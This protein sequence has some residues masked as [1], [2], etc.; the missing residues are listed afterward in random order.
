M[1]ARLAALCL[2][3]TALG[4]CAIVQDK[5]LGQSFDEASASNQIKSRL[6]AAGASRF[7]EVDVEV[8]GGLA[9]L[10]GRVV[11]PEDRVAA[12]RLAWTVAAIDEIANEI[13]VAAQ[14]SFSGG[15][16]DEWITARV[17]SRLVSDARVKSVN[18]NVETHAGVVYLLGLARSESELAAA[19]EQASLVSGVEKVVSYVKMRDRHRT[20]PVNVQIAQPTAPAPTP[21]PSYS[22]EYSDPYADPYGDGASSQ[23]GGDYS[24][25]LG[26]PQR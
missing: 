5:T 4:A 3:L 1:S 26:G 13:V 2:A 22:N 18:F 10:S 21:A 14:P 17:R 16:K 11:T 25:L 7:S 8:T 9:L 24:D 20:E 15:V 6:L 19:A 12:E 23:Q